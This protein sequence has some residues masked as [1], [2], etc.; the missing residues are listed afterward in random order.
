MQVETQSPAAGVKISGPFTESFIAALLFAISFFI[1]SPFNIMA[2]NV[3][4]FQIALMADFLFRAASVFAIGF[5]ATWAVIYVAARLIPHAFAGI[6]AVLITLTVWLHYAPVAVGQ[7]DGYETIRASALALLIGIAAGACAILLR[8]YAKLAYWA[9]S[10]G[11]IVTALVFFVPFALNA[12]S[13]TGMDAPVPVSASQDN[14]MVISM[15]SVEAE[16]IKSVLENRPDLRAEFDGFTQWPNTVSAA[17]F[18]LMSTRASKLGRV[19][20]GGGLDAYNDDFISKVLSQNGHQ[21]ETFGLFRQGETAGESMNILPDLAMIEKE[22]DDYYQKALGVTAVRVF[23]YA[24]VP[25]NRTFAGIF[26]RLGTSSSEIAQA[27]ADDI[28]PNQLGNKLEIA[29]FRG[30]INQVETGSDKPTL[31]YHH[32]L[33]THYPDTFDAQCNYI[34]GGELSSMALDMPQVE[35]AVSLMVDLIDKLKAMGVY[36]NTTLFF[37]SDHGKGCVSNENGAPGSYRMSKRWCLS[38]YMP[39]LLSKPANASGGLITRDDQVSL[40]DLP[41]TICENSNLPNKAQMCGRYVGGDLFGDLED[42]KTKPREIFTWPGSASGPREDGYEVVD[43]GR[44]QSVTDYYGLDRDW[45]LSQLSPLKCRSTVNFNFESYKNQAYFAQGFYVRE[46]WG[47][48]SDA[49]QSSLS[50][51]MV[52][53]PCKAGEVHITMV[54]PPNSGSEPITGKVLLNGAPAGEFSLRGDDPLNIIISGL[55]AGGVNMIT[56]E[57]SKEDVAVGRHFGLTEMGFK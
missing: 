18:T 45:S 5:V 49:P 36:D 31:R 33:F 23:P 43:L 20:K 44:D 1:A 57:R 14:V 16:D 22:R 47:R 13:A 12:S 48:R 21:V 35:C 9:A 2:D 27:I 34:K 28:R 29:S 51:T 3:Q 15:D 55:K 41:K 38:R 10:L 46:V 6:Y 53:K 56:F 19:P 24:S 40:I 32:Y 25:I 42:V 50:F 54:R 17:P 39:F 37:T 52:D 8:K 30:F 11:P 7:L 26:N 4:D